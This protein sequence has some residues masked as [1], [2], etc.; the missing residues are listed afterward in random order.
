MSFLTPAFFLGLGAIAIPVLVHLIQREKKRVVNFPSLM[1]V[2]Q[3]PYQSVRRRRIRH[4]FLLFMRAAAIALIVL[5]FARPFTRP[6]AAAPAAAS[7][8][9]RDVVIVLDQSASMGYGDHFEK[10]KD[11]ARQIVRGLGSDD[12]ATLVLFAKNAEENMRATSDRARLEGA[13]DAAKV[14]SGATRFGPALKLADSILSR[15]PLKRREAVLISDFQKTGWSG[16]EDAHFPD[17]TSL[18][19]ASVASGGT[20]NLSVPS[21]SFGRANFSGQERITVTA[22][23]SNKGDATLANIPVTLTID[24]HDI[25][26]LRASVLPQSSSSVTFKEFTLSGANV[27]GSVKAG[28]DPMPADNTFNFVLS[29]SEPVSILVVD[30]GNADPSLFLSKALSIG[31]TPQFQVD[32]VPASRFAP[33]SLD[34]RAVVIINDTMFPP[35][36]AGGALKRFVERGGGLL[37]VAGDHTTWPASGTSGSPEADLLPGK[38]GGAIDR[39]DSPT[40]ALGFLDYSHAVLEIF[41]AP[42]SGD[43]SAA[44]IY[45][46][47]S[48]EP[49]AGDR[50]LARYDDGAVAA[51]ERKIGNGR[52]IVWTSTLDDSFSDIGVKPIFLPLVHQLV[53]YLARYEQPASWYTV[54]QVLDLSARAKN[55]NDRVV[56]APS[57]ARTTQQASRGSADGSLELN[58]QGVYEVRN[59]GANVG[60]PESLAV[61]LDPAESDLAALDPRELVASVTGHATAESAEPTMAQEMT[62]EE[63]EKRQSLW[64][65]LLVAGVVLL[66]SETLISNHLSRKEKFL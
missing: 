58:E 60:R 37:I 12:R 47:R 48:I 7:A 21:V 55:R 50:V 43:F 14:T 32:V 61:N 24:G 33:G 1:F 49:A 41:K 54:G 65:Y 16:S 11:A 59:A 30:S 3:I 18:T 28:D 31:T 64:W 34:K 5:A 29:P 57:G 38:L 20:G 53:R 25:E 26:T 10:A 45:R 66:G 56:V 51:A 44:H 23:I 17:G 42:R 39:T 15:S 52:V 62:R 13:I 19:T 4:W 22:G 27:R 46:Y 36:A 8:G 40:G 6:G 35:G 63:T 9:A 2:R